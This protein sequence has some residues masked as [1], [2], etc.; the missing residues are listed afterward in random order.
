MTL[1]FTV[2]FH[3]FVSTNEI[4]FFYLINRLYFLMKG[5]LYLFIIGLFFFY[6]CT[7]SK[8]I[9]SFSKENG[10]AQTD[11]P[12]AMMH[13]EYERVKD[14]KTGEVPK[15]NLVEVYNQ[16]LK[17]EQTQSEAVIS[18]IN[19]T[20]RGPNNIG[21]RTRTILFDR[22]DVTNKTV[23]AASVGGGLFKCSDIDA[24]TPS[25]SKIND[26][27]SNIVIS[28]L[29]QNPSYPDTMY[30]GTGESFGNAD[31]LSG[32]GIWRSIDNGT[33][34]TQLPATTSYFGVTR[35]VVT[36]NGTIYASLTAHFA[37]GGAGG[38]YKSTNGGTSWTAVLTT[39]TIPATANNS[40]KDI[41]LA[42]NG[43]LYYSC[44]GQLWKYTTATSLWSNVTPAGTF[45]R[46]EI[47]CA[48][49]NS[50]YVYL[51]CQGTTSA[52]SKFYT[53]TNAATSWTSNTLPL[54]YDQT[55]T[56]SQEFTRTQAWYDLS[57]V[58]D[59]LTATTVYAGAIDYI[60]STDAG[61]TYKQIS[62]WSL[63]AMPAGA[64]LGSGQIMHSDHHILTFKPGS[65]SFALFGC[66]GGI[67]RTTNL[68]NTWPSVPSY[69]TINTNYN[70]TQLYS[71]AAANVAGSNNFLGGAQ[72]N[73][74][75]KFNSAGV[76]SVA[77]VSGGDGCF[78]YIDQN[79][80]NN[81]IT[82]YVYNNYYVSTNASTFNTLTG[83]NSTGSFVN[84]GELD[85][86]NDI[87]YTYAGANT[88]ARWS[89]VFGAVTRTNLTVTGVGTITHIKVSP[90]NASIIYIGN[91][92]GSVYKVT[93][94]NT[95]GSPI[96]PVLLNTVSFG[97]RISCIE[98]RKNMA[99]LDDTILVT[100]SN[101]GLVNSV[102]ITKNGTNATPTWTDIDDNLGTLPN[103]PVNWCLFVPTPIGKEVMIATDMGIYTC[104]DIYAVTPTWGQSN[105]GFANVRVDMLKIRSSD[106]LII[107][108]THGRGLFTSDKYKAP[109][110]DFTSNL[111]TAYITAPIQFTDGSSNATSWE[112][113][114]DNN[115][116]VD[117][118][119]KNPIWAFGTAGFKTVK[120]TINGLYVSTR[121]NY[122][123][124]LPNLATPF[125]A[126][127]GGN[128]ENNPTY[129]GSTPV[130]GGVNLWV[131]GAPTRN[132]TVLNSVSNGWKTQLGANVPSGDYS[133]AL[134]SPC[135]NFF[136]A[137]TY[138]LNFQK[139]M[140]IAFCNAPFA[141]QVQYST[142]LGSTWIRLGADDGAGT[143]WYNR[144]LING[145][146]CPIT[147]TIFADQTGWTNNYSN[148]VTSRDVSFLAGN[149]SVAFRIVF[150]V[151]SGY[152]AAAYAKD[153]FMIDD[154]TIT[155]ST[156][157]NANYFVETTTTSKSE[158]FGASAT[159][160]FY[161]P[162]GKIMA[163]LVNGSGHD[164][165]LT[166]VT[167][168]NAGTGALNYS[169]NTL[170]SRRLFQKTLAIVPTT[171]NVTGNYSS[172]LYF[173]ATEIS[174][175]R[176][177]TGNSFSSANIVKCP[178]NIA[179]GTIVNG[180][181][182][183]STSRALYG[184]FDSSI[185]ASFTTGF[186]GFSAGVD[187]SILPV[188]LLDFYATKKEN[189]VQLTWSTASEINNA[190]F[191]IERS[192]D[193][194]HWD[195][196]SF[197]T[198][199][200]T[201]TNKTNYS[202]LDLKALENE[203]V[204]YY[205]LKQ[206]DFNEAFKYSNL[207]VV[208]NNTPDI[209]VAITPQPAKDVLQISTSLNS[210]YHFSILG[211]AGNELLKGQVNGNKETLNVSQLPAGTYYLRI[212]VDNKILGVTPF[213][214]V[215]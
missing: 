86:V 139:S 138:T 45:Q 40:G 157:N 35:M 213:V 3:I 171:N 6:G 57:I 63:F 2:Y 154:F 146:S 42:A 75:L 101:Y 131:R 17:G 115:G 122:I 111:L 208:E 29:V 12:G 93:N 4:L 33:N 168:D 126:V 188:E 155:S 95:A 185:T 197:I 37:T 211:G 105:T 73:G 147:N 70:V 44:S 135:F 214:K 22:K 79:N 26:F 170:A 36:S 77:S 148:Q 156:S 169:T 84:P 149:K 91:S 43:D 119:T 94:A 191:T 14:P 8:G 85:G 204:L 28:C 62:A 212:M 54:I 184:A 203:R 64:N 13:W 113:D 10:D 48:P 201:S 186:S 92:T 78:V 30:F 60:K 71:C 134:M 164:Y 98:V 163:T 20:E 41:K 24:T 178:I 210:G 96:A 124:I 143:N 104:N 193:A 80:S 90:N 112:W 177:I 176:A 109:M 172:K 189:D 16:Y 61:A 190:G 27:F 116:S 160:D 129:F 97:G 187:V 173:D 207:R 133:C 39:T 174:G 150:S 69:A 175:W 215:N 151:A 83:S 117:A 127:N 76:N 198:G 125:T 167:I 67:Y 118:T 55:A 103:I 25:W 206:Q 159:V 107:A 56:I 23:F 110:A 165:G 50:N 183:T 53:S 114:F 142:D 192:S 51:L 9:T 132:L 89:N 123:Q 87:L 137:G 161:S 46:I 182:G 130:T 19:W 152:S 31:G 52:L 81:Q 5:I 120:L 199:K 66:D 181:Y 180:V 202:Y 145:I 121:T 15:Q 99:A 74:S 205:R 7:S 65:N 38:L 140:E 88:M 179:S 18:G 102:L 153:G 100:Q 141:V 194:I 34:W 72:D 136:K 59:P 162:N 108:A 200:G 68:S 11:E 209:F 158:Y 32:A 58:V 106:S 21:G 82:S 49:S 47:A 144:G 195:K 196:I 166:T 1:I 128:F